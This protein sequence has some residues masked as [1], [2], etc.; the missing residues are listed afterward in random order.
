MDEIKH[1]YSFSWSCMTSSLVAN[2]SFVNVN[3]EVYVSLRL[4]ST[5]ATVTLHFIICHYSV[6][7]TCGYT[8]C[9]LTKATLFCFNLQAL[10]EEFKGWDVQLLPWTWPLL[11]FNPLKPEHIDLVSVKNM[12]RKWAMKEEMSQRK[13]ASNSEKRKLKIKKICGKKKMTWKKLNFK[14]IF[15]LFP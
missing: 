9:Y 2:V 8:G 5:C 4:L 13:L 1:C 12:G 7:V 10:K 3:M 14:Y 15:F 6:P 11:Y